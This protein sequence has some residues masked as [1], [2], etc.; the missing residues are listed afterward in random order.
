MYIHLSFNMR[1]ISFATYCFC[2]VN[3]T[4]HYFTLIQFIS[5]Y[6]MGKKDKVEVHGHSRQKREEVTIRCLVYSYIALCNET[7]I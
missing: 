5:Y 1:L 3:V 7:N 6:Q 2:V 4:P